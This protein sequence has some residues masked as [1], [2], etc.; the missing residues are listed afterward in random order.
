MGRPKVEESMGFSA[1]TGIHC[2][3]LFVRLLRF[4]SVLELHYFLSLFLFCVSSFAIWYPHKEAKVSIS[5][6]REPLE[7]ENGLF[8]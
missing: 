8:L 1:S 4:G 6:S 2:R 3:L 5:L 7:T